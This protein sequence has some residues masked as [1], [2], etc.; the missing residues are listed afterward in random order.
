M[1]RFFKTDISSRTSGNNRSLADLVNEH[2]AGFENLMAQSVISVEND[3]PAALFLNPGQQD[4]ARIIGDLL[5]TVIANARNTSLLITADKYADVITLR[6][7][8]Q[9]NYNGYAMSFSLMSVE[10]EARC[11][12]G[13]IMI[14][15]AQERVAT[16]SFSFPD[17]PQA[18][19][20]ACSSFA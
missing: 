19:P 8:D 20:Y 15:G 6:V 18:R 1:K 17:Q 2:L 12:G 7:Q 13:E 14:R 5:G 16:I 9:N 4:I 3:V 11:V 10:R